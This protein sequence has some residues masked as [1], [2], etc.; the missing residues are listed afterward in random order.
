MPLHASVSNPRLDA[1]GLARVTIGVHGPAGIV[2]TGFTGALQ[3]SQTIASRLGLARRALR[4]V[5]L[6]NGQ[7]QTVPVYRA[8]VEC[9]GGRQSVEVLVGSGTLAILGLKLLA[10]HRLVLDYPSSV[11]QIE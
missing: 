5:L 1:Q 3:L 2:D 6:A 11:V 8:E 4:A 9:L 7:L 10:S